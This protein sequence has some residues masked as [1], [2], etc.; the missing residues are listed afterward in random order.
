M[1]VKVSRRFIDSRVS[2]PPWTIDSVALLSP[3]GRVRPPLSRPSVVQKFWFL[4]LLRMSKSF[5]SNES[6]TFPRPLLEN[7]QVIGD[8]DFSLPSV[9]MSISPAN[10][11]AQELL[12][13]DT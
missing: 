9:V 10:R 11:F 7:R 5:E 4:P 2:S 8:V 3:R 6:E 13:K 1:H 12:R